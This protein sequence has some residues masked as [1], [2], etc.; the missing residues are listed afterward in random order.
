MQRF[1]GSRFIA[2]VAARSYPRYMSSDEDSS[3]TKHKVNLD[4][5]DRWIEAEFD[6]KLR[7]PEERYAHERQREIMKSLIKKVR[8]DH[9]EKLKSAVDERNQKIDS[10]KDQIAE[11][12]KKLQDLTKAK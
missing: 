5:D 8:V 2:A 6:E 3:D 11:M 4:D 7:T 10:I 1:A 9:H 12:E